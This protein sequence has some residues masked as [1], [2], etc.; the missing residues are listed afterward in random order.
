[1][2]VTIV[3]AEIVSFPVASALA[4]AVTRVSPLALIG[5]A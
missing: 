5:H 4:S 2:P 3:S 1:M